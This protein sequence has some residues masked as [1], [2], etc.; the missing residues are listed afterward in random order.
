MLVSLIRFRLERR[1]QEASQH[2]DPAHAGFKAFWCLNTQAN[3]TRSA[4]VAVLIRQQLLASGHLQVDEGSIQ[5]TPAGRF[6]VLPMQWEGHSF[7]LANVYLPNDSPPQRCPSRT[8]L[9]PG[10]RQHAGYRGGIGIL[11]P[12]QGLTGLSNP[13]SS[14][15]AGLR[16]ASGGQGPSSGPGAGGASAQA[17]DLHTPCSIE[18]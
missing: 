14:R 5:R 13:P 16:S 9:A 4:G 7:S 10:S 15:A 6:M 18:D 1:L 8:H 11:S 12:I 2:N 17:A 3:G